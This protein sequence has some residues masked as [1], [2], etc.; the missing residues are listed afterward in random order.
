MAGKMC[1]WEPKCL[2]RFDKVGQVDNS[3][4]ALQVLIAATCG[5]SYAQNNG[6]RTFVGKVQA[7]QWAETSLPHTSFF[8]VCF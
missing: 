3:T 8:S 4:S 2:M 1:H 6:N 5:R 7:R